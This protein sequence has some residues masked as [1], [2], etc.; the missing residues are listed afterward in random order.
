MIAK[1][2]KALS[3]TLKHTNKTLKQW[4]Q[5]PQ[6]MGAAINNESTTNIRHLR[7]DSSRSHRVGEPRFTLLAKYPPQKHHFKH[8]YHT[9]LPVESRAES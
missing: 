4:K 9:W 5:N 1:R 2:R 6:T 3:A 8:L 7:A